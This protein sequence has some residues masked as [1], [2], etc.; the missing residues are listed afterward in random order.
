MSIFVQMTSYRSFDLVPTVRDCIEKA[1]DRENLHFGICLQQDEDIPVELNH[2][3]IKLEK[4]LPKDSPGHSWARRT[5]QSMYDG[6]DFTLQIEA[7]CRMAEGWDEALI[8]ALSVVGSERA[9]ITNPPNKFNQANGDLENRD[10]AYKQQAFQFVFDTPSFWPVPMKGV[11]APVRARTVSDQFMFSQGRHC[12]ECPYDPNL[13]WSEVE[14]SV[15]LRSFTLGYDLFHHNL[16]F[17]FRNYSARPM[18]WSD[19]TSWWLKDRSSKVR[20]AD[21]VRGKLTEFGLGS[22]RSLRDFELYS[23]IDFIGKRLQRDT[24]S[25]AD[26]PNKF[27]DEASWEAGYMKDWSM[28]VSWDPSKVENSDDYDYWLFGVEDASGTMI[29][30][31]D[32]RWERDR[33]ALEKRASA[34]RI[35]FKAPSSSKPSKLVVQPFSKSKGALAK[36]TFDI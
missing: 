9:I 36:A 31:Q 17:V 34:K 7:G 14:P 25:G 28:V 6:Q 10:M 3:R 19:D 27:V 15:A 26:A 5:A 32:L 11:P 24:V 30:R 16:P 35:F 22:A 20:F 21:L 13:Y 33:D 1:R 29:N 4:V 2:E 8:Q 18:N 12:T 23:G